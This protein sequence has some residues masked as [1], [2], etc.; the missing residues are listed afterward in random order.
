M[1]ATETGPSLYRNPAAFGRLVLP[2]LHGTKHPGR[3]GGQLP[4]AV[5]LRPA[6]LDRTV[7]QL[8]EALDA[9]AS[10]LGGVAVLPRAV[11]G[12]QSA[13]VVAPR[14][15]ATGLSDASFD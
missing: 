7:L 11:A 3:G 12:V 2:K 1:F 4:A 6:V 8:H 10:T 9:Q 5:S 14:A 13:T 15:A